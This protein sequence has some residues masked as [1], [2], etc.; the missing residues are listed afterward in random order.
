MA[1]VKG[2]RRGADTR[3]QAPEH[4]MDPRATDEPPYRPTVIDNAIYQNG[5]RVDNP[6]SLA[7]AFERLKQM[8]DSM[9]WIGLYRPKEWELVKLGEEFELHELALEDAIVGSQRPKADR[10]GDTLFVVL[11][12]ARYL[13]EAEEVAFGELHIFIGPNFVITVRHAEAPDLV[14]VRKRME[15]DPDLLRQGPQAVLY[16]L[17]DAVVDGYAPVVAGL[18]K[19]IEE[20]EVEVF[21]GDPSVSRRVYELSGEVIEFQRATAPLIGMINGF[22]AGARKYGVTE[23]LQSYLRDVTDHAITVTERISS[24]R[25]MLQNILIVNSTLVTQAQNAEM[26]RMTEASIQQGEEVKRISAWAAILFAPTLVGTI[27][28]MNFDFMPETHWVLGYPFA[29]VLMGAVCLI[30][31]RVFKRR[32]WL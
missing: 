3:E 10:Y 30:L 20:I 17:L 1:R 9:A 11:R 2:F 29:I 4:S 5:E 16:A 19:D 24:F 12:A 21:S 27:Y 25:Q 23:E 26:A 22:M 14:A 6:G 13:D 8:P 32:N 31:H 15:S 28:G 18:Q 7:D